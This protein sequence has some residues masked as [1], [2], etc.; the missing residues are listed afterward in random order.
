MK[1]SLIINHQNSKDLNSTRQND[2]NQ[3]IDQQEWIKQIST[4]RLVRQ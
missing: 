4:F 1:G 2:L 3:H